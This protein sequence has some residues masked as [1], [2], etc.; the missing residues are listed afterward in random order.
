MASMRKPS[1]MSR[2]VSIRLGIWFLEPLLFVALPE[3]VRFLL[4]R[5]P[6]DPRIAS[7]VGR[8]APASHSHLR[9]PFTILEEHHE[10]FTVLQLFT[11]GRALPTVLLWVIFFMNLL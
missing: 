9:G 6:L 5:D 2:R 10:S 3:S 4:L 1:A 8:L 11:H 7:I